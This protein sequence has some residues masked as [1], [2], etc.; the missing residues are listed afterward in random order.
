MFEE[1]IVRF[2]PGEGSFSIAGATILIDGQDF[3]GVRLAAQDLAK[4]LSRVTVRDEPHRLVIVTD[5]D[6]D[7][8]S[9]H[10]ENGNLIIIGTIQSSRIIEHLARKGYLNLVGT[11]GKWETFSTSVVSKPFPRCENALVIAGSDKRGAIFG[12]YT[13]SEQIGVS[14]WYWWADVPPKCHSDIFAIR[15][16]TIHGEPSIKHR[17]IF[18]NDEAPALTGW[19]LENFGKYNSA[20]YRK[21][22]ELLL[23]LKANFLWPAMWP[24]YPNPGASFFTDD[25]ETQRLADEY[26]I[27]VS[28]SH[29]EPMQRLSNEWF[30]ENPDGSWN[31]LTNKDKI[32]KFFEDGAERAK[33]YESYFTLGMRGEYD[34]KMEGE[35]PAAVV[36]DVL[37]AQRKVFKSVYGESDSVPRESK[38]T[39]VFLFANRIEELFAIYKEVQTLFESGRLTVPEDVTLLFQDDNFGTIRRL[40]TIEES[41]RKGGA[42]VRARCRSRFSK[43]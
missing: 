7:P 28:T 1:E 39:L 34:K 16:T 18:L 29:H 27:V 12:A 17:G 13:L 40:P 31:W 21:I 38:Q 19:V 2:A 26:G 14:P 33:G 20:F 42:G 22:F 4:D 11:Q 30:A 36:Q 32:T 8:S 10:A 41:K 37:D 43:R 5:D 3:G 15:K 9:V 6:F 24:G 35:D 25:P 23:R